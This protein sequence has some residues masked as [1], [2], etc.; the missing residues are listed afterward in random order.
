MST[1]PKVVTCHSSHNL[2]ETYNSMKKCCQETFGR[3]ANTHE[4][5]YRI[6]LRA[7]AHN[8][9]PPPNYAIMAL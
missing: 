6:R 2:A 7:Y 3:V 4:G 5:D 1:L 9:S 8:F